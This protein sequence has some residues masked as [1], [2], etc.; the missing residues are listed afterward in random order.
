MTRVVPQTLTPD[1]AVD[2]SMVVHVAPQQQH[3]MNEYRDDASAAERSCTASSIV[4]S[5]D[6]LSPFSFLKSIKFCLMMLISSLIVLTVVLLSATWLSAF[7]P[8]LVSLGHADRDH[9]ANKIIEFVKQTMGQI[10][11]SSRDI[12]QQLIGDHFDPYSGE[13]V[14]KKMY[15][16]YKSAQKNHGGVVI[17][18]YIGDVENYCFGIITWTNSAALFNIT[19]QN[20]KIYYCESPLSTNI[21]CKRKQNPDEVAGFF[22]L[23]NLIELCNKYPGQQAFS[24][25]YADPA[26]GMYTF[27]SLVNCVPK[28]NNSLS[29]NFTY[30][31]GNDLTTGSISEF[32]KRSAASVQGQARSFI[33]ETSTDLLIALDRYDNIK[34]TEWSP[35][36]G[37]L[38]RK[39][40]NDVD[41]SDIVYFSKTALSS[42]NLN[43]FSQITCNTLTVA[44]DSQFYIVIY[45]L[46]SDT[47][48]DWVIV[49]TVPQWVYMKPIAIAVIVAVG[50]SII[51]IV[52]GV[53]LAV[54]FSLKVSAPIYNLIEL[55]ERVSDMQL[56][57]LE[58]SKSIFFEIHA[59]QKQFSLLIKRMKL[60]RSF[61]PSHL[62]A[63]VEK[64]LQDDVEGPPVA[65]QPS[66]SNLVEK[67]S[68]TRLFS[69]VR[70]ASTGKPHSF[71]KK[72]SSRKKIQN[73]KEGNHKFS[74]YLETKYVTLVMLLL[75]GLNEWLHTS[76]PHET[77]SLL[78][79]I[80][81][82]INSVSRASGANQISSLENE[83]LLLAF[84]ATS[85]QPS[86]EQKAASFSHTL[87]EKLMNLKTSKWRS[88]EYVQRRPELVTMMN[89]RFA[90]HSTECWLGNIGTAKT[91]VFTLLCSG[92]TN[93]SIMGEVSKK[94]DIP[95]VCSE[96]VNR[97]CLKLYKSRY[98]DTK[99]FIEDTD[100]RQYRPKTFGASYQQ[101]EESFCPEQPTHLFQLGLS[102]QTSD[103]E[104]MYEM[105]EN[106]KKEE[107]N[108][109]NKACNF[110]MENNVSQALPLFEEYLRSNP[111]DRP[112]KNLI[113]LC[114]RGIQDVIME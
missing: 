38:I 23:S 77:V 69:V 24:N 35:K 108:L 91:K 52:L 78:S 92:K 12:Q 112:T 4:S 53:I 54:F 41:D 47:H 9:E 44:Q 37:S 61:I 58:V 11:L 71:G 86:H 17:S 62:L 88:K 36:D 72:N 73:T 67:Q 10:A 3:R 93:L 66:Q 106:E 80:F 46:C 22:D 95:I 68:S 40:F 76:T 18:S 98:V 20:Q 74:L 13:I 59:L 7:G 39:T 45:R 56:D 1:N 14:E 8:S 26:M 70:S 65:S 57:D 99:N 15:S 83:S 103:D 105:A 89:F 34:I 64:S 25:S 51:I 2:D 28:T 82:Q 55:F 48:L 32:L 107:W 97:A 6:S 5:P 43:S 33:I 101:M 94:M 104:W 75:D 29:A 60:Y 50:V 100:I 109:Y 110:F 49:L 30:Y 63:D 87:L 79:D 31:Y 96:N 111:N 84:N 21:E 114:K 81:D 42:L 90:I 27:V 19:R 113:Q 102:L 85:S 16:A